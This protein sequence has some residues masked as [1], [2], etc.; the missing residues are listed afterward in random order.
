[1]HVD[2]INSELESGEKPM[3]IKIDLMQ[4][5]NKNSQQK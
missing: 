5:Q 2:N 1:M 4:E 3:N